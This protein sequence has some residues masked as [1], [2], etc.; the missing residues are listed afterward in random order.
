MNNT[1]TP[2][3]TIMRDILRNGRHLKEPEWTNDIDR[4]TETLTI[5]QDGEIRKVICKKHNI[6]KVR[7][8]GD[9]HPNMSPYEDYWYWE[10][11]KCEEE[12]WEHYFDDY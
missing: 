9:M 12:H 7:K 4:E 11:P 2:L 5:D 3:S 10:C 8:R 6:E 1:E